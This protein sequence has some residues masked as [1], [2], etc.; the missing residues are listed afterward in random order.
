M[1]PTCLSY[2]SSLTKKKDFSE[3]L[4]AET[5]NIYTPEFIP[6]V[7]DNCIQEQLIS[8]VGRRDTKYTN[9]LN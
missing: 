1:S 2:K 4:N 6:F 5:P 9:Y 8:Y 7:M 3:T